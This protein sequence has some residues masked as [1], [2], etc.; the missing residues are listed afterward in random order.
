MN[1]IRG[2]RLRGISGMPMRQG[3]IFRPLLNQTRLEI[4]QYANTHTIPYREDKSNTDITYVRNRIRHN[5]LP[6]M[7]LINP[8]II[9]TLTSLAEYARELD[10]M[11]ESIVGVHLAGTSITQNEFEKLPP[12]LANTFIERLYA[13]AHDESTIGLSS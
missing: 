8:S 11:M 9:H 12:L 3:T 5:I 7:A 6:E 4:E 1:I 2:S 10:S 13:R